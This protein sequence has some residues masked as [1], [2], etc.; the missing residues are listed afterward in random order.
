MLEKVI[1]E[2][3]VSRRAVDVVKILVGLGLITVLRLKGDSEFL[4]T[5]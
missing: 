4:I 2:K 1:I 3:R 5:D